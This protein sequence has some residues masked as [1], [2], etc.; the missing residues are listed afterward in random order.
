MLMLYRWPSQEGTQGTHWSTFRIRPRP[1]P[2]THACMP[3]HAE[4]KTYQHVRGGSGGTT[5]TACIGGGQTSPPSH[6][7]SEHSPGSTSPWAA[8]VLATTAT[9]TSTSTARIICR[10]QGVDTREDRAGVA[11]WRRR[12]VV[13]NAQITGGFFP[14]PIL[15]GCVFPCGLLRLNAHNFTSTIFTT[16]RGRKCCTSSTPSFALHITDS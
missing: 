2:A 4:D 9:T 12:C 10:R 6:G 8:A 13:V 16:H 11:A 3:V 14:S 15:H 7:C 5:T 1:C